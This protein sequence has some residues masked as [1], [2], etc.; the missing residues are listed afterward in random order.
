M[1]SKRV[2]DLTKEEV[3]KL[4]TFEGEA[5]DIE[6]DLDDDLVKIYQEHADKIGV[7]LNQLLSAVIIL[8]CK[9]LI[10]KDNKIEDHQ[11]E[12]TN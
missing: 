2:F 8:Y 5:S 10:E 7:E 3:V 6:V 9:E 11:L 4:T 1:E 12:Y